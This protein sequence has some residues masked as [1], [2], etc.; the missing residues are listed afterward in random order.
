MIDDLDL[1]ILSHLQSDGRMSN[2]ELARRVGMA[3]SAVLERV[4]RM[5]ERGVILGYDARVYPVSLGLGLTAF[6]FVRTNPV[7]AVEQ[8][9]L[10]AAI[11]EVLEVHEV[12]GED[13]FLIKVRVRDTEALARLMRERVY[14]IPGVSGTRTTIVLGT[15]KESTAMPLPDRSTR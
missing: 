14:P 8:A 4:R 6:I 1:R 3:P 15:T 2:A 13:C 11:P 12:A 10:L 5:E 7:E 9:P